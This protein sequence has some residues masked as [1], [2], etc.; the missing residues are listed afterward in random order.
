M[1]EELEM[2]PWLSFYLLPV[3]SQ[4][5]NKIQSR[6]SAHRSNVKIKNNLGHSHLI[7]GYCS[8][9]LARSKCP[10]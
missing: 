4:M 6:L 7:R 5:F 9:P 10:S 2:K 1:E 3:K 8:Q